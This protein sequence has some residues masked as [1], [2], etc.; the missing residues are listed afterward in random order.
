MKREPIIEQYCSPLNVLFSDVYITLILLG[1]PPIGLYN[2]VLL[3]GAY[4]CTYRL[5]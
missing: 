4:T 2:N 5:S 3:L 1:D